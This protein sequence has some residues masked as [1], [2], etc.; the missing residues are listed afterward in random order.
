MIILRLFIS[1]GR[2]LI[3]TVYT[4]IYIY[5]CIYTDI[6]EQHEHEN[7]NNNIK[8]ELTPSRDK[9]TIFLKIL[10]SKLLNASFLITE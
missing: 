6:Y 3:I 5:I 2:F 7:M 4:C 10:H 1:Y 9:C 8:N